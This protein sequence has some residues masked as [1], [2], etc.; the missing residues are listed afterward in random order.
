MSAKMTVKFVSRMTRTT[1]FEHC[2]D[3]CRVAGSKINKANIQ[4]VRVIA[5]HE[6]SPEIEILNF[7]KA[8]HFSNWVRPVR[9]IA[10]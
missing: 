2:K 4:A 3:A 5:F 6:D 7:D 1:A 10:K 9:Q 8:V